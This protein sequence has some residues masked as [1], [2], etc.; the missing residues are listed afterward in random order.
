M[1]ST[2]HILFITT[3]VVLVPLYLY[4]SD[5]LKSAA[6]FRLQ[7]ALPSAIS[8]ERVVFVDGEFGIGDYS[9][10][11]DKM[12]KLENSV[13]LFLPQVFNLKYSEYMEN[14]DPQRVAEQKEQYRAF[15]VKL[16]EAQNVIPVIFLS[17]NVKSADSIKVD[18]SGQAYFPALGAAVDAP[19]F[20]SVK[21]ASKKFMYT[22]SSP[23]FY[24][25]YNNYMPYK[26]PVLLKY[27]DSLLANAAVEAVRKYYKLTRTRIRLEGNLLSVG[28]IV[29]VP[30]L[31]DATMLIHQLKEKPKKMSPGRFLGAPD[32]ELED[33]VIIVRSP[34]VSEPVMFSL[35]VAVASIMKAEYIK[36][37]P[38][39]NY[40]GAILLF[41]GMASLY[42]VMRL[43]YGMLLFL[44]A[45]A[46]LTGSALLLLTNNT[47]MDIV[48]MTA[49]NVLAFASIY[50][51]RISAQAMDR[52]ARYKVLSKFMHPGAV[53]RFI[54]KNRDIR[55]ENTWIKTFVLYI[56]FEEA[57]SLDAENAKK[58]F[59]KARDLIYNDIKDF[60]I[61][62][63]GNCDIAAL[64]LEDDCGLK[65]VLSAVFR[66]R[67]N[68]DGY[69]FNIYLSSTEVFIF[70][71]NGEL[72]FLD[73]HYDCKTGA[74]AMEKK[75]QVIVPEADIQTY[76]NTAKFQKIGTAG[77]TV[78]FNLAGFR[79]E[80]S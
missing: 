23:G 79:E 5:A 13:A 42:R 41:L 72:T 24:P 43:R 49:V 59:V 40:A 50:F 68:L 74:D 63:H 30:L 71:H 19:D 62:I 1:K 47:Y 4:F 7:K 36:Y 65:K 53:R 16:A 38:L 39:L 15:M 44:G 78:Y 51:Y 69:K 22:A 80:A 8:L 37:D 60:V 12:A 20:Y 9:A 76:V 17:K 33:K 48:L 67:E 18:L 29:S 6:F 77:K 56:C 3:L 52:K 55:V 31:N 73:R 35:A 61:K 14:I 34:G 54:L 27:G 2:R 75:K 26:I 21:A 46:A 11:L 28:D 57:Y 32:A 64:V 45:Q 25:E 58:S 70:E 66:L 10:V